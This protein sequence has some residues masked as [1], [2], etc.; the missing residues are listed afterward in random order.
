MRAVGRCDVASSQFV[1]TPGENDLRV[2][3]PL[4]TTVRSL[5]TG[6]IIRTF[7]EDSR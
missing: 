7:V 6:A 2:D 3:V 5:L 1:T 4:P